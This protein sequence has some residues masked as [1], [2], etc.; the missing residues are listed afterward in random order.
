MDFKPENTELPAKGKLLISD[1]FMGDDY[2]SRC[3]ILL[4]EHNDEGSFGFILNKFVEMDLTEVLEGVPEISNRVSIGGPVE[5]NQLY[6]LHTLGD[7]LPGSAEIADGIFVGGDY[8]ILRSL[9]AS[10]T[11]DENSVRFF[12]GYS[13]WGEGQLMEEISFESWYVSEV[14]DLNLMD[15]SRDDLWS[16]AF[17][18][19]GGQFTALA[20]FPSD[21]SLN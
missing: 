9:L 14:G 18:E 3:V 10:K 2:F 13:G 20:N 16:Q 4:C 15:T 8:E 7:R 12:V 21:P 1:P 6:F 5:N 17:R 11:I 19:M